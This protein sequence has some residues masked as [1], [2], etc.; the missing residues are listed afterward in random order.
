MI[1]GSLSLQMSKNVTQAEKFITHKNNFDEFLS[2]YLVKNISKKYALLIFFLWNIMGF[3][4]L[5]YFF[6]DRVFFSLANEVQLHM[7]L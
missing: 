4:R 3:L 1:L 5:E 7:E 6:F 2:R